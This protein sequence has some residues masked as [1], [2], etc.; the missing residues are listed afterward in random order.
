MSPSER[1]ERLLRKNKYYAPGLDETGMAFFWRTTIGNPW[2]GQEQA[3]A[4]SMPVVTVSKEGM[5]QVCGI[6]GDY[7]KSSAPRPNDAFPIRQFAFR[8][9]ENSYVRIERGWAVKYECEKAKV[10]EFL[11]RNAAHFA[12]PEAHG[13]SLAVLSSALVLSAPGDDSGVLTFGA[14]PLKHGE[15]TYKHWVPN[16]N[17]CIGGTLVAL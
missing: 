9:A 13:H 8:P 5:A 3:L 12:W 2:P 4:E 7:W 15:L 1:L 6:L 10:A 16:T 11:E 17:V 14:N